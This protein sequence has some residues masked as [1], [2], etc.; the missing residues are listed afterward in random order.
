MDKDYNFLTNRE[1]GKDLFKNQSQEKIAQVITE[2]VIT[3]KDF[4]IIGIDGEWGSGKSNLVKLVEDKLK[5]THKFFIYDV[6][7][8]QEDDQ[9]RAILTELTDFMAYQSDK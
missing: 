1:L 7:G 9:R 3:E 6:W 2:K 8:H 4:K 5:D